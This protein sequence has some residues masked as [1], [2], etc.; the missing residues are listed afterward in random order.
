MPPNRPLLE[1]GHRRQIRTSRASRRRRLMMEPLESRNLLAAA[2]PGVRLLDTSANSGTVEQVTQPTEFEQYLLELI[3]RGRADPQAEAARHG[4]DLNQ[5]LPDEPI[6]PWPKQPLAF[7]SA[8]IDAARGHSQWMLDTNQLSHTGHGNSSPYDRMVAAGYSFSPPWNY[9]ENLAWQGTTGELDRLQ[10]TVDAHDDLFES[11]VH[12]RN[13][14]KDSVREV[15]LGVLAGEFRT[16][17]NWNAW[18][19]TQKFASSGNEPF[20]TGVVYD[21]SAVLADAFYTPGE[22]LGGVTIRAVRD[23]DGREF[24]TQTWNS[25]GY[26]LPLPSGTY[27]VIASGGELGSTRIRREV[28]ISTEN[29]K[30]DFD[31]A[32][33]YV[34]YV[35][36]PEQ[37]F[38]RV[39]SDSGGWYAEVEI[40]FS[41]SGF[42]VPEWGTIERQGATFSVGAT[43]QRFT[44]PALTVIT[45]MIHRYALGTLDDGDYGFEFSANG[46]PVKSLAFTIPDLRAASAWQ[47][48][49]N[50]YDV[51]G[52][53][54]VA[55]RDALYLINELNQNG[56]REL[57]VRTASQAAEPPFFDVN[58][59][60]ALTAQDALLV[61]NYLNQRGNLEGEAEFAPFAAPSG[62]RDVVATPSDSLP[63]AAPS[64]APRQAREIVF[65]NMARRHREEDVAFP[66]LVAL[67]GEQETFFRDTSCT[68]AM[69]LREMNPRS[70]N[71]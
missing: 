15:G 64:T 65:Q 2:G 70:G 12:R 56:S 32:N 59:D 7:S 19:V 34:P 54:S 33:P 24:A 68:A 42:V 69:R 16:T 29:V 8:L 57:P 6:A 66:P 45:P 47:N 23:A 55:P 11:P 27:T 4:I 63:R 30:V 3:N 5:G 13:Q 26:T 10:A 62:T 41:D 35:P 61:I 18:M 36:T 20:L 31:A 17:R 67:L 58:G 40:L 21:D 37:T 39:Q 1:S 48:P 25:G 22:G 9:S 43:I 14:L 28:E 51:T 60:G 49:A 44:G 46:E 53:G 52:N 71:S 38:L 50:R